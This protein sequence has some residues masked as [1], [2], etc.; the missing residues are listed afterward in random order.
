MLITTKYLLLIVYK[1]T[2]KSIGK[3]RV[4]T[5]EK[6]QGDVK[7]SDNC[8]NTENTEKNSVNTASK[9][10]ILRKL[11]SIDLLSTSNSLRF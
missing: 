2:K 9:Q 6:S 8:D 11:R 5:D 10:C 4:R 3:I 7:K 1:L